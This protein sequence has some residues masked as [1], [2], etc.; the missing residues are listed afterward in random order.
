MTVFLMICAFIG[1]Y[2]ASI[3]TW[4]TVKMAFISVESEIKK[5]EDRI[6]KLTER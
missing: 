6:R 1:G 4:Q 2:A 3:Y 5:L